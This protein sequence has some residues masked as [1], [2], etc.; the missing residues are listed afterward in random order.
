MCSILSVIWANL[1]DWQLIE[2]L[3]PAARFVISTMLCL[4]S[5]ILTR[6]YHALY[7]QIYLQ[8]FTHGVSLYEN[9]MPV[10]QNFLWLSFHAYS[11]FDEFISPFCR[12][13]RLQT[14]CMNFTYFI[15]TP[16]NVNLSILWYYFLWQDLRKWK[17]VYKR[18]IPYSPMIDIS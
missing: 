9:F 4:M 13:F 12:H 18:P 14:K 7:P 1:T 3:L 11:L 10:L 8:L 15:L 5:Q 6:N 17:L 16:C 2:V